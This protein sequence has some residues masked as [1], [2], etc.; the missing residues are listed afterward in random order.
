MSVKGFFDNFTHLISNA[1][2]YDKRKASVVALGKVLNSLEFHFNGRVGFMYLNHEDMNQGGETIEDMDGF[3][4]HPLSVR[5]TEVAIFA[6]EQEPGKFRVS[7]RA[8][9]KIKVNEIARAFD[10]GGHDKAAG[11]RISG[12]LSDVREK[13]LKEA[14]KHL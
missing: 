7:L 14:E 13:L 10:G 4:D 3:V 5:G 2:Y 8:K 12:E 1:V 6:R 11:C 9:D